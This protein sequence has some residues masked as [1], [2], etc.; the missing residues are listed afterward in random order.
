MTNESLTSET[1][2]L[3]LEL[4]A[5]LVSEALELVGTP[6]VSRNSNSN[7]RKIFC[8]ELIN[9]SLELTNETLINESLTLELEL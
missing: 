2:E 9:E 4:E 3:E 1:L 6:G 7:S 5:E 8:L